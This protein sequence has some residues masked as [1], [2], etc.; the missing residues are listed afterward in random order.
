LDPADIS[1]VLRNP[2]LD[3]QRSTLFVLRYTTKSDP[4]SELTKRLDPEP[5]EKNIP[6]PR[7]PH[8]SG[9]AR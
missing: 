9:T 4:I 5:E 7:D 3:Y 6:R 1:V 2:K 8:F